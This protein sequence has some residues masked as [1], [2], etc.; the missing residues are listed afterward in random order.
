M[1]AQVVRGV[2][3]KLAK[4]GKAFTLTTD[5]E[6]WYSAFNA[7]QLQDC[8]SGDEVSFSYATK[9][10]NGRTFYNLKGDLKVATGSALGPQQAPQVGTPRKR[11]EPT[12][13]RERLILTQNA[14]TASVAFHAILARHDGQMPGEDDILESAKA[15]VGWTSSYSGED[16]P[17]TE[18]IS[19][20]GE[21]EDS[22]WEAATE[23]FNG[24]KV[25]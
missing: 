23:S 18:P 13:Q 3:D 14:L 16:L 17:P 12:L 22:A 20:E 6:T 21:S 2:V 8:L 9:E 7:S 24:V 10:S 25:A 4:N 1:V 15:F 11:G 19:K 5:S